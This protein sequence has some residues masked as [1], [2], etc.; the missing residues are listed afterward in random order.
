MSA[1][2]IKAGSKS[3]GYYGLRV[4][5]LPELYDIR[6]KC[7]VVETLYNLSKNKFRVFYHPEFFIFRHIW[8]SRKILLIDGK[9]VIS[10]NYMGCTLNRFVSRSE[11]LSLFKPASFSTS[12]FF[13]IKGLKTKNIIIKNTGWLILI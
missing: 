8:L 11:K 2:V 7:T 1:A 6:G 10:Q 13:C 5:F 4:S 9:N 3:G 12:S